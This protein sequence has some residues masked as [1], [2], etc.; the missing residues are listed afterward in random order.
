M[1]DAFQTRFKLGKLEAPL[2][3]SWADFVRIWKRKPP[4]KITE[5]V[6]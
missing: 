6:E 3:Q 1:I 2:A 5:V 4:D